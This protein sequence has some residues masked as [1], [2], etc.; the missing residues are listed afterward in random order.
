MTLSVKVFEKYA[1]EV[2]VE[3]GTRNGRGAIFGVFMGFKEVHTIE[4]NPMYVERAR[5]RFLGFPEIKLH[6]GD[7]ARILPEILASL[8]RKALL[9]L[10]A[11]MY[12]KEDGMQTVW[13][14]YP[15]AEELRQIAGASK[16]RDHCILIDDI[17]LFKHWGTSFEEVR[18]LLLGINAAY[19][20]SK[21]P[22][23][24]GV[25]DM[26]GAKV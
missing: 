12:G 10:D 16:R 22:N 18:D 1:A 21:E 20:V 24:R 15:L 3:T 11:H 6:E 5:K 7:S 9:L 19:K 13:T 17:H 23:D 2:F 26:V 4:A 25:L 14:K 8:D